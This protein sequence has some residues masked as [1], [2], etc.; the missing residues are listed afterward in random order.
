MHRVGS[1]ELEMGKCTDGVVNYNA[2]VV[3]DFLELD[4]RF[5]ALATC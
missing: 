1:P 4:A 5:A 3:E 2:G